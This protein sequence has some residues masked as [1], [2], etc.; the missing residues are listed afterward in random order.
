MFGK[1]LH[2]FKNQVG[3]ESWAKFSEQFPQ[4]LKERLAANY[5]VQKKIPDKNGSRKVFGNGP[6]WLQQVFTTGGA[7]WWFCLVFT[8]N[9][10]SR[11]IKKDSGG[12]AR[13]GSFKTCRKLFWEKQWQFTILTRKFTLSSSQEQILPFSM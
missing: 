13:C 4:P 9:L 1:I 3:E 2:G 6:S 7:V 12:V 5:G 11:L 8:N 10:S